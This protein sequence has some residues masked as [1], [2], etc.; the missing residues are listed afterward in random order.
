MHPLQQSD[1][2][3]SKSF[4]AILPGFREI[5]ENPVRGFF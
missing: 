5:L 3:R 2:N 4:L 1:K